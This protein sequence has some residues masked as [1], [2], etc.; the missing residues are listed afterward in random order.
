MQ[1]IL[2]MTTEGSSLRS[3]VDSWDHE[4]GDAAV[5]KLHSPVGLIGSNEPIWSP[6]PL[7]ALGHGWRLLAPPTENKNYLTNPMAGKKYFDWYFTKD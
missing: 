4:D 3:S 2:M 5:D 1:K 7:H 6:T